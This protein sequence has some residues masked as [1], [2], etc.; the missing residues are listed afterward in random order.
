LKI[1]VAPSPYT[2]N[3]LAT[4]ETH[5]ENTKGTVML[6]RDLLFEELQI[7]RR[8]W[9]GLT[10]A[11]PMAHEFAHVL[12]FFS[13]Y[14]ERLMKDSKTVQP[15]ELHADFLAGYHLGLKRREGAS[16]DIGA[17][18][19]GIYFKGDAQKQDQQHHGTQEERRRAVR[20]GYR[21]GVKG[22]TPVSVAAEMGVESIKRIMGAKL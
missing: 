1:I 11:G 16:M 8:G 6:G 12:Q 20:E 17:F 14:R 18:M 22:H 4:N 13:G 7:N 9:G 15:V 3:A 2:T 19:D 10:V 5:V 21:T